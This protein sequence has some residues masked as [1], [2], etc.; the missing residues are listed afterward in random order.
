MFDMKINENIIIKDMTLELY[1]IVI[2]FWKECNINIEPEDEFSHFGKFI[3]N[4]NGKGFIAFDKNKI[5]GSVLCG[6]DGRYGYIHHLAVMPEVRNKGLGKKLVEECIFFLKNDFSISSIAIFVWKN[7]L[8]GKGFWEKIGF[9]N[10]DGLEVF[11]L[12]TK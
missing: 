9:N 8:N 3:S 6:C 4:S 1:D 11:S 10:V 2:D 5:I 7:N 12:K